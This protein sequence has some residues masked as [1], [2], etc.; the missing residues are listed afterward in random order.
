MSKLSFITAVIDV[1]GVA[2]VCAG[3]DNSSAVSP[4]R[5]EGCSSCPAEGRLLQ[6]G[7]EPTVVGADLIVLSEHVDY[8]DYLGWKDPFAI[9]LKPDGHATAS[10]E[11]TIQVRLV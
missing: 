5:W 10:E 2:L 7:R 9:D 4:C 8:W 1:S 11:R 3:A 6:T